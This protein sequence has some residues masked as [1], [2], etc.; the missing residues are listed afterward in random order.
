M[1]G[2]SVTALA[3]LSI[4]WAK[5]ST[6]KTKPKRQLD[7]IRSPQNLQYSLVL[8]HSRVAHF[9]SLNNN[10]RISHGA[11][12]GKLPP[13]AVQMEPVVQYSQKDP[14]YDR[15]HENLDDS[16]VNQNQIYAQSKIL[17]TQESLESYGPPYGSLPTAPLY[18]HEPQPQ[19]YEA[20]EPIIEIII[21]ESNETLPA[22][23][24]PPVQKKKK[25]PVHVFYVKYSKDPHSH[26]K[27][28]YDKPIPAITPSTNEEE[29]EHHHEEYI[30]VTPEPYI[31]RETTTLRALIKPDS[32]QYHS[33]SSV[34]ITFGNEGRHYSDRRE[35][36]HDEDR[37]E[38]APKPAIAF[39]NQSPQQS[40]S[41]LQSERAASPQPQY[42]HETE[43]KSTVYHPSAQ[44]Y[45]QNSQHAQSRIQFQPQAF[46][47]EQQLP[48]QN[49]TAVPF[50]SQSH[51]RHPFGPSPSLIPNPAFS[52]GPPGLISHFGGPTVPT[53][54]GPSF[55][56]AFPRTNNGPSFNSRPSNPP[57]FGSRPQFNGPP[58]T[59]FHSGP[60]RPFHQNQP[61]SKPFFDEAKYL[62][63][64]YHTITTEQVDPPKE[65]ILPSRQPQTFNH[66]PQVG[67][68]PTPGHFQEH[69][70]RPQII[71]PNQ[72]LPQQRPPQHFVESKPSLSPSSSPFFN[73]KPSP[74][75]IESNRPSFQ[76]S[77]QL[78]FHQGPQTFP[79]PSPS[80][81][82][83]GQHSFS[84]PI[85][86]S[87]SSIP[88]TQFLPQ[89][90]SP[91]LYN[92]QPQ[93]S[94]TPE[95]HFLRPNS[96]SERPQIQ[97]SQG[98]SE[99]PPFYQTHG[100]SERPTFSH[101]GDFR[102]QHQQNQQQEPHIRQYNQQIEATS[103]RSQ[104]IQERS[105]YQSST[106][107]PHY[108][109][110]TSGTVEIKP[111]T[112][113]YVSSTANSI[114][115]TPNPQKEDKKKKLAFELPD[116]VPDD[117]RQQ[118]LSSGILDNA[119]ISVLDYDKV[120]DTSLDSLPPDQLANF[121][122]AGGAQQISA[123]ENRP[124]YVKPDGDQIESR[125]IDDMEDD[126][127]IA[128]SE[129]I[130]SYVAAP[131]T[132]K[133]AVE[134]KV[135]HFNPNTIEGQQIA[136][137]YV[138][139]NAT[140]VEPVAL[141][142]KKYNRYLPLKVSG[143]QFPLP[144]I[145][146][147]RKVTSVVVLAPVETEAL[148]GEHVRKERATS[149]SLKGIKF[150]FLFFRN[151]TPEEDREIFM[152]DIASGNVN[153]LSGEL[154]NAFVEAAENNSL[155]KNI[156]SLAI[157]GEGIPEN[158]EKDDVEAEGSENVPLFV[159][160]SGPDDGNSNSGSL[161]KWTNVMKGWQYRW[162]VLDDNAGLLSYYTYTNMTFGKYMMATP[163]GA[164]QLGRNT[165]DE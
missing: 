95:L 57:S 8:P 131:P 161:S 37:E 165:W 138:Q 122:S 16:V 98:P 163:R 143:N 43:L 32:E 60:Q 132:E 17:N 94:P 154:S 13:Y 65:Q 9:R 139:E 133:Q 41:P 33:H 146:K 78:G 119:D 54:V 136:K 79:G 112:Q 34:K 39:P 96:P 111:S 64:N 25:E 24:P 71:P 3:V 46:P 110:S 120:G 134:M 86:A 141:N 67:P 81:S 69:F 20:P 35:G 124:I 153:K 125:N 22:P 7:N 51:I 77:Q 61:Q 97:Q 14:L 148:N 59:S 73:L 150:L 91:P 156:E 30:T 135:V 80:P 4:A 52:N 10:R 115:T 40:H 160:I 100:P 109:Q 83:Q 127:E 118:L 72:Q 149:N 157:E 130:P 85:S 144:D 93:P 68:S 155:S 62:Q 15:T 87:P 44:A 6:A 2:Q 66:L 23:P 12:G 129:N 29:E 90:S 106:S 128:A 11:K 164:G 140:Q 26:D 89:P 75:N 82:P 50:R 21:K 159:D 49:P 103:P 105:R 102:D 31:P 88:Q 108:Y 107:S 5:N 152:Y 104:Y 56:T 19:Y 27:V 1:T 126:Q 55:Q 101:H 28:I 92:F 162:F 99:R 147:G 63:E 58:R 137:D 18:S 74:P 47:T 121:F 142:D 145:L 42:S 158:F 38:T 117:L 123:S 151:E 116:E 113:K 48:R 70:N 53:P 36:T 114:S 76:S 45:R 84:R